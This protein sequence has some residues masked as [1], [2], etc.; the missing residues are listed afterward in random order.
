[1]DD[2]NIIICCKLRELFRGSTGHVRGIDGREIFIKLYGRKRGTKLRDVARPP[3]YLNYDYRFSCAFTCE[4]PR[5]KVKSC[6]SPGDTPY[7]LKQISC[8]PG[9][10][11]EYIPKESMYT[12]IHIH[13]VS[14]K[15]VSSHLPRRLE[16]A[17]TCR[18][19]A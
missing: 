5:G 10:T 7:N 14:D 17:C 11:R 16:R 19:T 13:I 18:K 2:V 6:T 12:Y 9:N 8:L 15:C 4:Y 1:M 3:R